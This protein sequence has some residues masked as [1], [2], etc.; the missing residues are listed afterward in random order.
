M[1]PA[2]QQQSERRPWHA[3]VSRLWSGRGAAAPAAM[4]APAA[5][6][7]PETDA[8]C[9][10]RLQAPEHLVVMVNGLFGSR[11]NWLVISKL[12]STELDPH[13]TLL[14]VS[15]ANERFK[16]YGEDQRRSKLGGV[17]LRLLQRLPVLHAGLPASRPP[18]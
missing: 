13:A 17:T 15:S 6:V 16:T 9:P 12:L 8:S 4:A 5:L 10:P 14:H 7:G 18:S 3:A 11:A 2:S 1:V